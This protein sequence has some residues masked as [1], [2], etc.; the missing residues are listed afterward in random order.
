MI[1]RLNDPDSVKEVAQQLAADRPVA[2]EFCAQGTRFEMFIIPAKLFVGSNGVDKSRVVVALTNEFKSAFHFELGG[3]IHFTYPMEKLR[4]MQGDAIN[5]TA[6]LNALGHPDGV[7]Y[8]LQHLELDG[9]KVRDPYNMYVK[10]R[11]VA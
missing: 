1:V 6:F 7:D 2:C 8:Y 9:D 11:E 5:M 4:L 10:P 3:G